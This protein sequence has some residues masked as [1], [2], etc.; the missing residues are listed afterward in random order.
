MRV[1]AGSARGRRLVAPRG[2][3]T[4]PTSDRVR[5]AI[6]NALGSLDVVDG[7]RVLDLFA[8]SGALGIEALSRGAA[9]ATFVD[10]DDRAVEAIWAN[11]VATGL[12]D[13]AMVSAHD[14]MSWLTRRPGPG[15][16]ELALADPPYA[17]DEWDTLLAAAAEL[18]IDIVVIESD[19]AVDPGGK[20]LMV[21]EKAYGSTVVSI[22]RR[23]SDDRETE[24]Y[25]TSGTIDTTDTTDT[26]DATDPEE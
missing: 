4:R 5:E 17:F 7:A 20:W 1:V 16:F 9:H 23:T 2:R 11:L 24:M 18:P 8:G 25:A 12:T 6:F 19:R 13:R 14:A 15:A 10:R 3:D 22:V 26:T 21:R